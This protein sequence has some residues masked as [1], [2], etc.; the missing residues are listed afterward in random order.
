MSTLSCFGFSFGVWG[1][2]VCFRKV[3]FSSF[4]KVTFT[5]SKRSFLINSIFLWCGI[6]LCDSMPFYHLHIHFPCCWSAF[7]PLAL[8]M[9]LSRLHPSVRV[10][11]IMGT[12]QDFFLISSE[13]IWPPSLWWSNAMPTKQWCVCVCVCVCVCWHNSFLKKEKEEEER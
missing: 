10:E 3:T 2:S 8:Q 6:S 5:S 11:L 4:Q 9:L 1:F 12:D 13:S 7:K